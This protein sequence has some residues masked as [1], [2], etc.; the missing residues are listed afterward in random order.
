MTNLSSKMSLGM[1]WLGLEVDL[2]KKEK[3]ELSISN[4]KK[5]NKRDSISSSEAC[6]IELKLKVKEKNKELNRVKAIV[7]CDQE[8][9]VYKHISLLPSA[10]KIAKKVHRE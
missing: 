7:R 5:M 4:K 3:K 10:T 2:R 8:E 6:L 1:L 9:K